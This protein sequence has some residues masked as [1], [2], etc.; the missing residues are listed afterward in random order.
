M[1]SLH[2]G[3]PVR[4]SLAVNQPGDRKVGCSPKLWA[5][6]NRERWIARG[7][8]SGRSSA[9]AVST[10]R[11]AT[12]GQ[13]VAE[14]ER[15]TSRAN[16]TAPS[17]QPDREET[18][19]PNLAVIGPRR[20]GAPPQMVVIAPRVRKNRRRPLH[21]DPRDHANGLAMAPTYPERLSKLRSN[22]GLLRRRS[23]PRL[24]QGHAASTSP[25][26]PRKIGILNAMPEK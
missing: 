9:S 12:S 13:P 5:A 14:I 15:Q 18:D 22:P 6:G 23:K 10:G 20:A 17:R 25:D 8:A 7:L 21:S 3:M 2:S 4:K 16:Q 11:K 24:R 19:D 26:G 1:I